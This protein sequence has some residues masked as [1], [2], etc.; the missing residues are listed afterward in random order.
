MPVEFHAAARLDAVPVPTPR[1]K[2]VKGRHRFGERGRVPAF[3][4][5][6]LIPPAHTVR[7]ESRL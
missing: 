6:R 7:P 3:R 2:S 4:R 5:I 1:P